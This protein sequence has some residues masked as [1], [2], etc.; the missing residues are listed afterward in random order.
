MHFCFAR[1][2]D[3]SHY[4]RTTLGAPPQGLAENS[5]IRG[6]THTAKSE[7]SY[8]HIFKY[9]CIYYNMVVSGEKMQQLEAALK[10][11][12]DA[13]KSELVQVRAELAQNL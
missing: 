5:K 12:V 4:L 11:D 1:C 7:E 3:F 10:A 2:T 8:K 9:M 6:E 13:L